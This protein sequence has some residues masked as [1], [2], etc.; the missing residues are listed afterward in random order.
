MNV[1]KLAAADGSIFTVE[2]DI[3]EQSGTLRNFLSTSGPTETPIPV[4]NISGP[5]LSRVIEYCQHHRDDP[6]RRKPREAIPDESD[7]SDAAIAR[8]IAQMDDYDME[9]CK[10]DQGTLFDLIL[11]AN[12]L[13]IQPLMDL[14]GFTVANKMKG[15]SVEE[16][17]S[18]FNVKNDFTPEEEQAR[19]KETIKHLKV[20][21]AG[22]A[23]W[24]SQ[25]RTLVFSLHP[26]GRGVAVAVAGKQTREHLTSDVQANEQ[27]QRIYVCG[28]PPVPDSRLPFIS[29]TH[30]VFAALQNVMNAD[31][32]Q[33]G[34][35][36]LLRLSA[37]YREAML[38]QVRELQENS[39]SSE[40]DVFQAMHAVWHLAEIMYLS[41]NMP[42]LN[43]PA[44]PLFLEWLNFN[45]PSPP[46]EERHELLEADA[47]SL[48]A[49]ESFWPYLRKLALRGH[50]AT[51]ASLLEH[52]A[53]ASAMSAAAARWA[54]ELAAGLREMPVGS[55]NETTGSFNSRWRRWHSKLQAS[56]TAI[57]SLLDTDDSELSQ[58]YD[59]VCIVC[60]D[61]DSISAAADTWLDV[62]GAVLLYCEP[63]S[64]ADRLPALTQTVLEQF[65]TS[66]FALL[67]RALVALLSHD[68]PELLLYCDQVDSW[69]SAHL[70]DM[71]HHI[72]ILD[73][74][75][76]VFAVDPREHYLLALGEQYLR[77]DCLWQV[78]IDYFG[79]A[80]SRAG[81]S[82]MEE[83]LVRIPLDSDR[84]A[85]QVL[86]TCKRYC[87]ESAQDRIHR[88]LGRQKWL[89]GRLGAAI[90]HFAHVD[91][92]AAISQI[93]DQLWAE[94]LSSGKLTYGPII[95]GV[96]ATGL[97]H[98]RLQFLTFYRDFHES[99]KAGD[100]E[101]AA[102][103]LLRILLNDMAP[104]HAVSDLLVDAIPLLEADKPVFSSDDTFELLRCAESL[105]RSP[106]TK[107]FS[108]DSNIASNELSIFNVACARNLARS[109][110]M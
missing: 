63:A 65:Q 109:F 85:Q 64:P 3:V 66:D 99:Y 31:D 19:S 58:I 45:F 46:P 105:A 74:C 39:N 14:V 52:V 70:T 24:T 42:G 28:T 69:L 79:L 110:V 57:S 50:V 32:A 15:K 44:V 10:V 5:I 4:P 51:L 97:K 35:D 98:E 100:Y 55:A 88:Q 43:T 84:K 81:E 90:A 17:R 61:A 104:P 26:L 72:G 78:A 95:D 108:Q 13:D 8:A 38:R 91:D 71:L 37:F 9:F 83:Y 2:Q 18:T 73:S 29:A 7:S 101:N 68:L 82:L 22:Q 102:S 48:T 20:F 6:S 33:V 53:P 40:T 96:L 30:A 36:G 76:R 106:F 27:D 89:R 67:D 47:D 77:H 54:R 62:L 60:G 93:C 21:S 11:A 12:F 107:A 94:Y 86:R 25:N 56:S 75:R 1:Y 34:I 92:R 23:D 16:I 49:N 59:L 80:G 41:T 103:T 87:L